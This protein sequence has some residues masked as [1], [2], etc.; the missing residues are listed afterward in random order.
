LSIREDGKLE[1]RELG[2]AMRGA[3]EPARGVRAVQLYPAAAGGG[4]GALVALDVWELQPGASL[5]AQAH[6]EEQ[7]VY[8]LSGEGPGIAP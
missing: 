2:S 1:V 6:P 3:E 5:S 4:D 7:L 8:V